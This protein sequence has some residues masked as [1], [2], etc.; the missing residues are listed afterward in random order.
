MP[1][2]FI[3]FNNLQ[4]EELIA[5]KKT[6]AMTVHKVSWHNFLS[7]KPFAFSF[8]FLMVE[9]QLSRSLITSHWSMQLN[10][11]LSL[12]LLVANEVQRGV[13][14]ES[15]SFLGKIYFWW[16][17]GVKEEPICSLYPP[18]L[19]PPPIAFFKYAW[20]CS[21]PFVAMR[22]NT[23]KSQMQSHSSDIGKPLNQLETA[24]LWTSHHTWETN[25]LPAEA[26]TSSVFLLLS[27]CT[28]SW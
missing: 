19:P 24:H 23:G 2:R 18:C 5:N 26:T 9:S 13:F 20:S 11:A 12:D 16:Q 27:K 22:K 25:F 14:A 21:S 28:P 10:S 15:K 8:F 7:L 6:E 1:P 17:E 4:R 3:V